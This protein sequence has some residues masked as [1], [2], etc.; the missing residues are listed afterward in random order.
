MVT[1][2]KYIPLSSGHRACAG[3]GQII[4]ARIVAEALGPNV[5]I[6]NAT[7]CLEV[8]TTQYPESAWGMPWIH[9]LFENTSAIASGIKAAIDYKIKIRHPKSD[10][11]NPKVVAQGGDGATFDIGFGLISGMW[12]RNE[13]ILY[14]C[15]D[16]EAY[17]NTGIQASGSTP[18]GTKTTTTPAGSYQKKK[19]MV[20]IAL[21]HK[22]NYVAQ[23][24][25][26]F[27][28]DIV[29]K[30][31]KAL[32]IKGPGYIQILCPCV[33]GW[34]IRSD[35]TIK[36]GKLAAQTAIY[37]LLEYVNGKQTKSSI[38]F[39]QKIKAEEYFKLQGRFSTHNFQ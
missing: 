38:V 17:A 2:K 36:I 9:S 14:I 11:R 26:G 34:K 15:Y 23:T 10:I 5:I 13:N 18:A 33:P 30:I 39:K 6:A 31:K 22:L 8:T 32:T 3:C 25:V 7:G 37:P 27:P 21:A 24:T 4:A 29:K 12:Q 1:K 35:Q 28:E 16:N 20:A 19:D